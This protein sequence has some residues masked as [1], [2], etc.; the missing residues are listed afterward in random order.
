MVDAP[1]RSNTFWKAPTDAVAEFAPHVLRDYALI[2]D[3][4]R[5]ALV[6]PRGAAWR[7]R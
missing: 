2:A 6:G 7:Q 4:Y 3:G 5:G 1:P